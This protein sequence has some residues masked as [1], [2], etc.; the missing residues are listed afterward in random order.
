MT[1]PTYSVVPDNEDAVTDL[2]L[3]HLARAATH[4]DKGAMEALGAV[5]EATRGEERAGIL[6]ELVRRAF[7]NLSLDS[8]H[9]VV[10]AL[11]ATYAPVP[12]AGIEQLGPA[13]VRELL[14]RLEAEKGSNP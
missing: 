14:S 6:S 4:R 7:P 10:T 3:L 13:T 8:H 9:Q 5:A 1:K 12:V 2:A 11:V